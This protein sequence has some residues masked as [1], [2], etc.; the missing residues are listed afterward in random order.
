MTGKDVQTFVNWRI[1]RAYDGGIED[2]RSK[3]STSAVQ[4]LTFSAKVLL[5]GTKGLYN[6]FDRT[7]FPWKDTRHTDL[8]IGCQKFFLPKGAANSDCRKSP[9]GLQ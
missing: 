7:E 5:W 4:R 8:L 9:I 2:S 3:R 1:F 6:P